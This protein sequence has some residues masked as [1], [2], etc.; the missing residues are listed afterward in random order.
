VNLR[1]PVSIYLISSESHNHFR[2]HDLEPSGHFL[3][4]SPMISGSF[5]KNDLQLETSYGYS[6][7]CKYLLDLICIQV[8]M[9]PNHNLNPSQN[10]NQVNTHWVAK[11]LECF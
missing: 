8:I 3:Q 11:T 10:V 2:R 7:P 4:N 5:E 9:S 1:H 6:P